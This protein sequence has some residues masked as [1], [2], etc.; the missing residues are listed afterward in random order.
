MSARTS[1]IIPC[2]NHRAYLDEAIESLVGQTRPV[3]EVI[4]VDD[5]ST[6]P[7]QP[8]PSWRQL[9]VRIIRI[10]NRGASAARNC[11]VALASGDFIAFLD[12]D[13]A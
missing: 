5:G 12:A 4:V 9:P 3:R 13:D 1:V 6:T 8:S 2:H 11:G 10:E 7:V